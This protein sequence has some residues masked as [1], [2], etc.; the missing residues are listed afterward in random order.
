[1][2]Q[3]IHPKQHDL[4]VKLTNG[5]E[6][7]IKTTYGKENDVLTL[8]TDPFK[9]QAWKKDKNIKIEASG[10]KNKK[11]LGFNDVFSG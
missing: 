2:A 7:K 5:D 4:T 11:F 6:I 1:M 9:H 3:D 10:E 8:D